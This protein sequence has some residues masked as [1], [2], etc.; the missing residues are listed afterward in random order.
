MKQFEKDLNPNGKCFQYLIYTFPKLF[1]DKIKAGESDGPQTRLLVRDKKF[2]KV[3][4]NRDKATWLSFV[5][6]MQ[7]FL[8]NIKAENYQVLLAT[9][10]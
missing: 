5:A 4:I 6:V 3:M 1:C 10:L 7:N 2:V 8:E 9:M